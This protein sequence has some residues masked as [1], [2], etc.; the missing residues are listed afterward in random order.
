MP[1]W[2]FHYS[3]YTCRAHTCMYTTCVYVCVRTL[4]SRAI[5]AHSSWCVSDAVRCALSY[6]H[7]SE[8]AHS[9]VSTV[10]V[11]KYVF[12]LNVCVGVSHMCSAPADGSAVS[13]LTRCVNSGRLVM[14]LY[15]PVCCTVHSLSS[16]KP[17]DKARHTRESTMCMRWRNDFRR[18]WASVLSSIITPFKKGFQLSVTKIIN[19]VHYV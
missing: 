10:S 3:L 9:S 2:M 8:L 15:E 1:S 5:P 4:L 11:E 14:S 17:G 7:V 16:R 18:W 6:L 13:H 19:V 12:P